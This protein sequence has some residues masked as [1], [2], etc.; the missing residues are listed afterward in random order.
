MSRVF[1]QSPVFNE[2]FDLGKDALLFPKR[3]ILERA[4]V[5][6][7]NEGLTFFDEA[8]PEAQHFAEQILQKAKKRPSTNRQTEELLESHYS[9]TYG[10]ECALNELPARRAIEFDKIKELQSLQDVQLIITIGGDNQFLSVFQRVVPLLETSGWPPIAFLPLNSD[11]IGSKG[12]LTT[13]TGTQAKFI[14]EALESGNFVI[15]EVP[16]IEASLHGK[17][18]GYA[19]NEIF[20]GCDRRTRS[21]RYDIRMTSPVQERCFE[22]THHSSGLLVVNELGVSGWFRQAFKSACYNFEAIQRQARD[23][24]LFGS[25]ELDPEHLPLPQMRGVRSLLPGEELD[26][27]H[28]N[29]SKVIVSLDSDTGGEYPVRQGH[30]VR[31]KRSEHNISI[32]SFPSLQLPPLE[33]SSRF[34]KHFPEIEIPE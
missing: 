5:I 19:V 31:I 2:P 15:R 30:H 9:H 4:N 10:L 1:N 3:D 25:T 33:H 24:L 32:L 21:S 22:D 18:L 27:Y 29:E 11:I 28:V 12:A 16:L 6:L 26:I 23:M 8:S 34:L 14:R 20:V 17:P 7:P 13:S